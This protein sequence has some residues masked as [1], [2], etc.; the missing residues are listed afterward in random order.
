VGAAADRKMRERTL[1]GPQ[2]VQKQEGWDG[3][4]NRVEDPVEHLRHGVDASFFGAC[5]SRR[6][7]S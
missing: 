6:R 4:H 1:S 2:P 3:K 5:H 7:E